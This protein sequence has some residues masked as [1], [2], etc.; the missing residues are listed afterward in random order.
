MAPH[1]IAF[2]PPTRPAPAEPVSSGLLTLQKALLACGIAAPLLYAA[3]LI[4]VPTRW[5]AYSSAS[6]TVSELSAIG[7][8]TRALWVPLGLLYTVL[9]VAFGL[10]IWMSAF[11]KRPLRVVGGLLATCGVLGLF[12]PPMHL[13][14]AEVTLTDTLHIVW[15]AVSILLT[16][17]A[18][19]FAAAALGK[20]FRLYSI[21]TMVLLVAFGAVAGVAGPR[22][23][24]NLPTPWVGVWQRLNI[25]V[26]MLWLIVLAVVLFRRS[27]AGVSTG[28]EVP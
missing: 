28:G 17:I 14:G 25:G 19:G 23:Q 7:A 5:A 22:I 3:M 2:A 15:T 24:A 13:R 8:P 12:W 1:G 20:R 26:W 18:M 27:A 10:G 11:G 4:Y 16:L 9:L 21:A 6:Q